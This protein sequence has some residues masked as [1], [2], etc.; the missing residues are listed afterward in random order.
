MRVAL[1]LRVSHDTGDQDTGNQRIAL[2]QWA[3]RMGSDVAEVYQVEGSAWKGAHR[4]ALALAQQDARRGR[5]GVLL[6]WALDRL[7]RE[8]VAAMLEAV[9]GF[10]RLGCQAWSLQEAWTQEPKVETREL[11]ISVYGWIAQQE[12]KRRSERTLAGLAKA[13]SSGKALG[14]PKGATDSKKRKR[15]GYYARYAK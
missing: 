15:S 9:N 8:G 10:E 14:R 5:F 1:W 12:S 13:K 4:K 7:S 6:V 3:E 2:E 11:L